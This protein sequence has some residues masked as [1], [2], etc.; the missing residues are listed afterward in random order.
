MLI[1]IKFIKGDSKKAYPR[2]SFI[3][4]NNSLTIDAPIKFI[5]GSIDS[6][7]VVP[8]ITVPQKDGSFQ[9]VLNKQC[10]YK[11]IKWLVMRAL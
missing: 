11:L 7:E 10:V 8:P 3:D 9:I 6:S 4:N 2:I 5:D 1:K